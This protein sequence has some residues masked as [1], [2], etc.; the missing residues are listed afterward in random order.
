MN[1]KMMG[2]L[3]LDNTAT[4]LAAEKNLRR[5]SRT[6][7]GIIIAGCTIIL[8]STQPLDL[9]IKGIGAMGIATG[10]MT[11]LAG[12]SSYLSSRERLKSLRGNKSDACHDSSDGRS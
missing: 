9:G 10:I 6:A 8:T 12:A 5:K 4:H 7:L 11:I 1:T 2:E 3:M